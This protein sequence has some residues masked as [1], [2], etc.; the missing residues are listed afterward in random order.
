MDATKN[1]NTDA[2][3]AIAW[4]AAALACAATAFAAPV[5]NDGDTFLHI[6]A[7]ARMIADHAVLFADPFSYTRAGAPWDAHEW[8]AEIVMAFAY[9]AG[10]WSGLLALFA[11]A[12]A[13]AAFVLSDGIGRH[14]PPK[15]QGVVTLLAMS[16]MTGSLL[17]RPHLLALPL[18]VAWTAA[19]VKARDEDR[20]P[21][22]VFAAVMA[23]W[24]N[25]HASFL[26]GFALAGGLGLEAF[27]ARRNSWRGW[28]L[29]LG[30]SVAVALLNPHG[31]EG[32][33]F[34]FRLMA[35][36]ALAHI[37]EWQATPVSLFQP[38]VPI[39]LAAV[40]V[41]AT[42]R[43][44][45]PLTRVAMLI[46]LGFLAFTHVRHQMVFAAIAP[47]LLAAP[48]GRA[49]KTEPR[50]FGGWRA[51]SATAV[52]IVAVLAVARLALPLA[53]S[54]A[55]VAPMTAL[56]HVPERL[57]T[58]PMLND[59]AFGGYLIFEG[60]RPFIDSRAELYGESDLER[61]AALIR[62]D[63]A[64]LADT[65]R[66]YGI[67]WSILPPSSPVVAALSRAGWRAIY[68]DRFAVV[69]IRDSHAR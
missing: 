37:G 16:G 7:G 53:R 56:A 34:P 67:S 57:R 55:P 17:A 15:A 6:A 63:A 47:P 52:A 30:A 38:V 43:V 23:L 4:A 2:R 26:L 41:L 24:V 48:L 65:T 44:R 25:I 58:Q 3:R 1:P 29:F 49:F 46:V 31:I 68:A 5:L 51:V 19:L 8:L 66:R 28:A 33:L 10:G 60:L 9:R 22:L 54:D 59:Y 27:I 42:R 39:T 13:G 11:V 69:Q 32:L 21:P 64:L 61:Y 45:V 50:T 36:P 12:A 14:L 18:L 35:M 20:A 62:P 40:Y